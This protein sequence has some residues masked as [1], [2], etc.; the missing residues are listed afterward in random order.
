MR[1]ESL[2]FGVRREPRRLP[3][4]RREAAA[5]GPTCAFPKKVQR[6]CTFRTIRTGRSGMA[7]DRIDMDAKWGSP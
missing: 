2:A 1:P 5:S 4:R 6:F 3:G 7:P